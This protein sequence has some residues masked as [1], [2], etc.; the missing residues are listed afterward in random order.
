MI[1][2]YH[3]V[4]TG[5]LDPALDI[6]VVLPKVY[7]TDGD[8]GP[9]HYWSHRRL[10]LTN[11]LTEMNI[12]TGLKKINFLLTFVFKNTIITLSLFIK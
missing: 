6:Y 8:V 4:Y 9:S 7:S 10:K 3:A 2:M 5:D 12:Y 11:K 1:G